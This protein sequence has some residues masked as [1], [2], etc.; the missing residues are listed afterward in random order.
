VDKKSTKNTISASF[1]AQYSP[2]NQFSTYM[3]AGRVAFQLPVKGLIV[4]AAQV[5]VGFTRFERGLVE[6]TEGQIGEWVDGLGFWFAS[7]ES[8]AKR[9]WELESASGDSSIAWPMNDKNC[10]MYGG[11]SFRKICSK[12]PGQR[13]QWLRTEFRQRQWNPL[14]KR[15]DI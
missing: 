2:D 11:C 5:A 1:F 12:A 8:C 9:G 6:R 14:S 13:Q 4:D 10:S 15:G 7:A 3:L